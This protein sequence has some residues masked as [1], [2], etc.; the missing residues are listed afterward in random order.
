MSFLGNMLNSIF[1]FID[2]I[3][4]WFIS[5]LYQVF[6]VISKANL[7]TETTLRSFTD[8]VFI[9]LGIVMLF[10]IA[11]EILVL[12]ISPEKVS[13]ENQAKTLVG[14]LIKSLIII[15]L[16]PTIFK[17]MQIFQTNI[18]TSNVI[19]NIIIGSSSGSSSDKT[20]K[21]AGTSMALSIGQ[22]FYHPIGADGKEYSYLDCVDDDISDKA[23]ACAEFVAA[24]DKALDNNDPRSFF[25][26]KEL[27]KQLNLDGDD[28]KNADKGMRYHPVISTISAILAGY[29]IV[30]FCIDI[31]IRVAKLGFLQII[32]PIPIA[33][34]ITQKEPLSQTTWVK[35]LISTYLEIFMKLIIIYFSM[36][37]IT[38]V[39]EMADNLF[40]LNQSDVSPLIQMMAIVVIILGI[41]QFAKNA[42]ELIKSLF[43]IKD[44]GHGLSFGKRMADNTYAS[45]GLAA[46]GAS[47]A[48]GYS[49]AS[50]TARNFKDGDI[51]K[52]LLGVGGTLGGLLTGGI[53]GFSRS[54][55][56]TSLRD[57]GDAITGARADSDASRSAIQSLGQE[58]E[59]K[60]R[61]NYYGD[62]TKDWLAG[63]ITNENLL[64]TNDTLGEFSGLDEALNGNDREIQALKRARE[65]SPDEYNQTGKIAYD[66][67]NCQG[68]DLKNKIAEAEIKAFE[69]KNGRN[70]FEYEKEAI[71]NK[72]Q[73]DYK[74]K[75]LFEKEYAKHKSIVKDVMDQHYKS[76]INKQK[77]T[78]MANKKL[79]TTEYS[80]SV[81]QSLQ[82]TIN[83][84]GKEKEKVILGNDF[85][86]IAE[87]EA[88][89]KDLSD[90]T[91]SP[92]ER[93][94]IFEKIS[95]VE[96][97]LRDE[98]TI[99]KVQKERQKKDK[100]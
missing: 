36:F 40:Q 94:E 29:M 83:T 84:L 67:Y 98:N 88:A 55:G 3:L 30:L 11:Y 41:L 16:L 79:V 37:A 25:V 45:R 96:N 34:N 60:R 52:G 22:A 48:V 49:N 78:N 57:I 80:K 18:L 15:I 24:Y 72:V 76:S 92:D 81:S 21:T 1:L 64:A 91:L 58:G 66:A 43:N 68:E 95:G 13:G 71:R 10:Y 86:S 77:V 87:F 63:G 42:P 31:G 65:E 73:R 27:K 4:Y 9:I 26:N 93:L 54:E 5:V 33:M 50:A 6:M 62:R 56:A 97:R 39:P 20:I 51:R 53:R 23:P 47:A 82:K 44:F 14:K 90:G 89:Y 70:M 99:Q 85:K 12:I 59:I 46:L 2:S 7:F 8:R 61:L 35:S 19:G 74:D 75:E 100:S 38:L 28:D 32:A 17:Y 69:D